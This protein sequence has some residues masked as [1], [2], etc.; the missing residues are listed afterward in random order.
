MSDDTRL[1]ALVQTKVTR[2]ESDR[3]DRLV[4]RRKEH[5]DP[6]A[7]RSSTARSLVVGALA[8]AEAELDAMEPS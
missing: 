6:R 3:L 8:Q 4:E 1:D 5:G 2:S 7:T